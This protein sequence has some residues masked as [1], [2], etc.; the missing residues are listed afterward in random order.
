MRRR[1]LHLYLV[2]FP[3]PVLIH[4]LILNSL[5]YRILFGSRQRFRPPNRQLDPEGWPLGFPHNIL[6]AAD[7]DTRFPS[8]KYSAW[9][10][11]HPPDESSKEIKVDSNTSQALK[12]P[13]A[14][15][16]DT[17]EKECSPET[18]GKAV[19]NDVAS[20]HADA[21]RECAI[22]MEDFDDDDFVRA[23]TCDHIFH[24]SCLDPWFTKRQAR[25]PL[26]KTC[27]PPQPGSIPAPTRPA[28]A[29]I[30]NQMFPR[31]L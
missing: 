27:Y 23:L 2:S 19:E 18:D 28:A 11:A 7:L 9:S 6:T 24:V 30:R 17:A 26:C 25:C 14:C 21:H 15:S 16:F 10:K 5:R 12:S 13:S 1:L 22:C 31:V 29:L 4:Y 8:I 20:N 3:C